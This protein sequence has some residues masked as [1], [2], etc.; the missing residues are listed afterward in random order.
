MEPMA[1]PDIDRAA[2]RRATVRSILGRPGSLRRAIVSALV[3]VGFAALLYVRADLIGRIVI[4]LLAAALLN[5]VFRA[6]STSVGDEDELRAAL[7]R[8]AKAQTQPGEESRQQVRVTGDQWARA[9]EALRVRE[10]GSLEG[11]PPPPILEEDDTQTIE[12]T[13]SEESG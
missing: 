10:S 6:R 8:D 11:A 1:E 4:F 12:A 9:Q 2:E 7:R 3:I 13:Q 5:A